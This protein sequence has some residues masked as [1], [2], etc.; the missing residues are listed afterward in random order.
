[1]LIGLVGVPIFFS[2][3]FISLLFCGCRGNF[4]SSNFFPIREKEKGKGKEKGDES[5][6]ERGG[7]WSFWSNFLGETKEEGEKS[8]DNESTPLL[9]HQLKDLSP[10]I[11]KEDAPSRDPRINEYKNLLV[12]RKLRSS[13]YRYRFIYLY[14]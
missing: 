2:V 3:N 1:M 7:F 13:R 9:N 10:S 5:N 8:D 12:C 14:L 11:Q 6:G 4:L